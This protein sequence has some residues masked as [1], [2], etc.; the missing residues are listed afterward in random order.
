MDHGRGVS[1]VTATPCAGGGIATYLPVRAHRALGIF[2][3]KTG[4][5]WKGRT[6]MSISDQ[7]H[8]PLGRTLIGTLF[9]D[10][11]SGSP[12]L[13]LSTLGMLIGFFACLVAVQL[14]ARTFNGVD[15]WDKP[16]KFFLSLAVQYATVSW[17]LRFLPEAQR[18]ARGIRFATVAMIAAGWF[19]VAYIAFR[20]ARAEASHFNASS[21]FS[22]VAYGV[23]G[24]GAITLTVTAFFIGY[25]VW[26]Q[27]RQGLIVE[28]AGMGLMV[29]MALGTVAGIYLSA[30]TGHWVGGEMSDAHGL[31]VMAW[32]TTGGD[33]RVAHFVGLHAAQ[34]VP[35]S[36]LSG[37]RAVVYFTAAACI[38]VTGFTFAQ[39]VLGLPLFV[40]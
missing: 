27:R 40:V 8:R 21:G 3:R 10:I 15:V 38:L 2:R 26:R 39:A 19:E 25:R 33:L 11:R 17:A 14:D 4:A 6:L 24:L 30:Q 35:F 22:Q 34:I 36:A 31:G 9:T 1:T 18:N 29:G 32:S 28:A 37:K 20:S 23:M 5:A 16:G 13:W 7:L 12:M